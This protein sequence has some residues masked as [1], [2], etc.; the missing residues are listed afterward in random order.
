MWLIAFS[1]WICKRINH[2]FRRSWVVYV[3]FCTVYGTTWTQIAVTKESVTFITQ[4]QKSARRWYVRTIPSAAGLILRSYL[5]LVS[6]QVMVAF[7]IVYNSGLNEYALYMDCEGQRS[8]RAY[9]WTMSLLYKSYRNHGHEVSVCL[10]THVLIFIRS[11]QP[12]MKTVCG[13]IMIL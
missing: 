5:I 4:A 11:V 7:G 8:S 12:V 2:F 13:L 6:P 10:W 1:S 9:D 3:C